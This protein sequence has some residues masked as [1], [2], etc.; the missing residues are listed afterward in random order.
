MRFDRFGIVSFA[1]ASTIAEP[2]PYDYRWV[3]LATDVPMNVQ[4]FPTKWD[5]VKNANK[6]T[7]KLRV[8]MSSSILFSALGQLT[9][10]IHSLQLIWLLEV[11][12]PGSASLFAYIGNVTQAND[13]FFL[14]ECN[15]FLGDTTKV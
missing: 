5:V 8:F 9:S 6:S 7:V 13:K 1:I 10:G 15:E 12:V 2:I 3:E 11:R 14:V 4:A